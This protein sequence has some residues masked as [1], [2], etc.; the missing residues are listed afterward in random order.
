MAV[1]ASVEREYPRA[2]DARAIA[3][4]STVGSNAQAV[5]Q[6]EDLAAA[7]AA[8]QPC[9]AHHVREVAYGDCGANKTIFFFSI[10]SS[11]ATQRQWIVRTGCA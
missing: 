10:A 7:R 1:Q 2:L 11:R 8:R 9:A 4:R 5:T 3:A 6:A